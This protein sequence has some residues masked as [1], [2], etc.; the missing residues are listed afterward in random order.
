M[1][2]VIVSTDPAA[3]TPLLVAAI[4]DEMSDRPWQ[5]PDR[6]WRRYPDL[7]GGLDVRAG[8][9]WLAA[10]TGPEPR[11]GAVLNG[12]LAPDPA[13]PRRPV[14]DTTVPAGV[15]RRSRGELPLL[16]ATDPKRGAAA[17][18]DDLTCYD[19]FHLLAADPA[20]AVL[21]SWDGTRPHEQVLPVGLSVVVNSGLDA[22][23]PRALRHGP[24]FAAARPDPGAR[25]RAAA[26]RPEE[27]WGDWVRLLDEAA[28]TG[29]RTAGTGSRPD[30]PAALLTRVE[31]GDGRVWSSN[32]ITLLAGSA[33]GVRY[34][35]NG[36]PGDPGAWRMVA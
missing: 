8:G 36:T 27:I 23:E 15:E 20:G 22:A 4:R 33:D 31:L 26:T 14:F 13:R 3:E 21:L 24:V 9:T 28:G 7:T 12:R 2:T 11:L 10:R 34:A 5:G 6:H 25:E 29:L 35:F 1:C 17:G 30:D 18:H 19:P 16:A 32:S